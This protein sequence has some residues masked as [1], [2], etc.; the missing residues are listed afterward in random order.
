[1]KKFILPV[2]A[3]LLS[4]SICACGQKGEAA[5]PESSG[6]TAGETESSAP[7]DQSA[8]VP[9]DQSDTLP[10]V[11]EGSGEITI[12]ITP[13]DGWTPVEGSVLDVQYMKNTASFM[14]KEEAFTGTTLDEI[15][16]EAQE[17]YGNA[18]DNYTVTSGPETAEIDG[19]EARTLTFTCKISGMS[20]KY[21]YAY[22]MVEGKTI[23]ITFGDLETSFDS[24][25]ADY[26]TILGNIRF[27]V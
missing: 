27:K 9:A 23:V 3:L 26:D 12:E 11:T 15:V 21:L 18:F 19:R 24:L 6:T 16:S 4:A 10:A 8:V 14:A 20:M 22:V 7:A 5:S 25:S 1:M 2:L 17:I 13:P